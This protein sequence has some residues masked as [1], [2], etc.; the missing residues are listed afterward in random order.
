[1][2]LKSDSI[3]YDVLSQ[4]DTRNVL[5]IFAALATA[6]ILGRQIA[7]GQVLFFMLLAGFAL[8]LLIFFKKESV[9]VLLPFI[10][11]LPNYGLDIPGPWAVTI[12]DAFIL[13]LFAAHLSRCIIKRKPIVPRG[14][15]I[16][17]PLLVFIGIATLSLWQPAWTGT[18]KL[19]QNIKDLMRITELALLYMVLYDVLDSGEKAGKLMR[20]LVVLGLFFV[21]V[22]YYIYLTVSPFFY[23]LLTMKPAYI[24]FPPYDVLRMVSMAGSTSQTGIFYAILLAFALYHPM[25]KKTSGWRFFRMVMIVLISSC[26]VLTLNRGTWVGLL[27]G[28]MVLVL[29]GKLDWKKITIAAMIAVALLAIFLVT[30]LGHIDL[31]KEAL[32][33]VDVSRSTGYA[34]WIR[35]VSSI[36]VIQNHPILGVGYN[37]YAYVY[38]L[39][40]V[41]EGNTA[42]YG[43]P[44]NMFVDVITGTGIVGF[45]AF[46]FFLG[47]LWNMNK[48]IAISEDRE[49]RSIGTG[50][51]FAFASFVGA[52]MFDSFFFKPHHS[53]ILIATTWALSTVYWRIATGRIPMRSSNGSGNGRVS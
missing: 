23:N 18:G 37:N 42:L 24:Y 20:N 7:R 2:H 43:S 14:S 46:L 48:R 34:R 15:P 22:S 12:E 9:I 39:Y 11:F 35:W 50:L 53:A 4:K 3:L 17:L 36:N 40:S 8:F 31:E 44:H 41:V 27:L 26:I 33:V 49:L 38:G 10:L 30:A 28:F 19:I 25:L 52:S 6:F 51:L 32:K 16:M 47:R 13:T 45:A 21:M 29:R 1:M 5:G